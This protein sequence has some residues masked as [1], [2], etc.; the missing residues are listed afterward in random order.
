MRID[1]VRGS[2]TATHHRPMRVDLVRGPFLQHTPEASYLALGDYGLSL[3]AHAAKKER[4]FF[5]TE[6]EVGPR[7]AHRMM[8]EET[9]TR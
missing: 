7:A 1:L 8:V 9:V 4:T 6:F 5:E 2:S 3:G